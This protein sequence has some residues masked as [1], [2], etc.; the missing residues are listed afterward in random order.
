MTPP[1]LPGTT[2]VPLRMISRRNPLVGS[3]FQRS[4][5]HSVSAGTEVPRRKRG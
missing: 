4:I 3:A 1:L 5:V 2:G